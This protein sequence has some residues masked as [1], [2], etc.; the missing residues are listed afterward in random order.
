MPFL[1]R[2]V[3]PMAAANGI[4]MQHP[5]RPEQPNRVVELCG[6]EGQF[7]RR[8]ATRVLS[9]DFPA[10]QKRAVFIED[11]ARC[12]QSGI[13]EQIR[14]AFGFGAVIYEFQHVKPPTARQRLAFA[15]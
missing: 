14:Q 10:S 8:G 1:R 4:H 3:G 5:A 15:G 13:R 2:G 7:I 9:P 12:D 6:H 11:D